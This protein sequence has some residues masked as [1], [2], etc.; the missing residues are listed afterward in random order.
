[1][2]YLTTIAMLRTLTSMFASWKFQ[3]MDT[4]INKHFQKYYIPV[5]VAMINIRLSKLYPI[6]GKFFIM[7]DC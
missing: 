6:P 4:H 5:G 1:M 7:T 2:E 3:E